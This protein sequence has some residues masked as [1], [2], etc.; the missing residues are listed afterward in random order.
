MRRLRC[1]R[2]RQCSKGSTADP[3][4]M[5]PHDRDDVRGTPAPP[6]GPRVAE[7]GGGPEPRL[8]GVFRRE[9]R[10]VRAAR[11]FDQ[12][13]AELGARLI[14]RADRVPD[15]RERHAF[16]RADDEACEVLEEAI[17][18]LDGESELAPWPAPR[19]FAGKREARRPD[20]EARDDPADDQEVR[21]PDLGELAV[22]PEPRD[23]DE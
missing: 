9:V 19:P 3:Q 1:R 5:D 6:R 2:A 21:A 8:P 16:G 10:D 7:F 14:L 23:P 22:E 15:P 20:H 11:V 18:L 17:S 13:P 12:E 4:R